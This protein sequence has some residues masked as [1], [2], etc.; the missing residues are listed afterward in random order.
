[1]VDRLCTLEAYRRK[2]FARKCME[3]LIQDVSS[4][5][6]ELQVA[7]IIA[8]VPSAAAV[9]QQKLLQ[10]SFVALEG[11]CQDRGVPCVKLCLRSG[12]T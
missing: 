7:A 2:G 3:V 8:I 10:A 12:T 9:L 5:G 6:Q 1:M 4:N 11:Q